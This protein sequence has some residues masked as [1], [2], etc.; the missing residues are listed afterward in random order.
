MRTQPVKGEM[1]C[2]FNSP[3]GKHKTVLVSHLRVEWRGRSKFSVTIHLAPSPF[4]PTLSLQETVRK[5]LAWCTFAAHTQSHT[6]PYPHLE[7]Y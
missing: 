6:H 1:K 5:H 4:L 2:L 3:P 7:D